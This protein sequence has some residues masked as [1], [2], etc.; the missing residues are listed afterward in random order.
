MKQKAPKIIFILSFIPYLLVLISGIAA[1]IFGAG[2]FFTNYYGWDGFVLGVIISAMGMTTVIPI[3]PVCLIY[4]IAYILRHKIKALGKISIKKYAAVFGV[5]IAVVAGAILLDTFSYDIR[6]AFKKSQAKE[7]LSRAEERIEYDTHDYVLDGVFGIEDVVH[8]TVLI[9]YDTF[10]VALLYEAGYDDY[11]SVKL[12][13]TS[14]DSDVIRHIGEDYYVQAEI[15]LSAP[16]K[17]LIGFAE[18]GINRHRTAAFILEMAD[19]SVYYA[20]EIKD[21]DGYTPYSG[22]NSSDYRMKDE[23]TRL[24]DLEPLG[25]P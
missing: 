17:R 7:M 19:G 12:E 14:P 11:W 5:I 22:L 6:A 23:D 4:Q 2:F 25:Q 16:G 18:S 24:A 3:I 21:E 9:D 1:A 15:P 10:E 20:D 8:D 13:K